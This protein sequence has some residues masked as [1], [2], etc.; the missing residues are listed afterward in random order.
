VAAVA[1]AMSELSTLSLFYDERLWNTQRRLISVNTVA[2][3]ASGGR[4]Q[5]RRN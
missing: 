2:I 5:R 4:D 1:A 3:I